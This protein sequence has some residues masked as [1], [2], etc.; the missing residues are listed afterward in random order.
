MS[1]RYLFSVLLLYPYVFK[2][3]EPLNTVLPELVIATSVIDG[4]T[5]YTR[6]SHH[7]SY[8]FTNNSNFKQYKN[9]YVDDNAAY[10]FTHHTDGHSRSILQTNYAVQSRVHAFDL[11]QRTATITYDL[12]TLLKITRLAALHAQSRIGVVEE[13]EQKVRT[14]G[15]IE[16]QAGRIPFIRNIPGL[17]HEGG[18]VTSPVT[19]MITAH[20]FNMPPLNPTN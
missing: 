19:L 16:L 17:R 7:I 2:A 10:H 6:Y 8:Q 3:N 1:M 20:T 9:F 14:S 15:A 12:D 18:I 5:S 11:E 13:F 4:E